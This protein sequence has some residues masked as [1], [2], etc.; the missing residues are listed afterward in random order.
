[1]EIIVSEDQVELKDDYEHQED[2]QEEEKK[3]TMIIEETKETVNPIEYHEKSSLDS[4][5]DK[6]ADPEFVVDTL[7][8]ATESTEMTEQDH[9]K[10]NKHELLE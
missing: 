3:E 8:A 1:M 4:D 7:E 2:H 6:P 5:E 9:K 10:Y